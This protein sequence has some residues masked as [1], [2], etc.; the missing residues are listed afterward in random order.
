[1]SENP[2]LAQQ[3]EMP[4]VDAMV[5]A[6]RG[7]LQL[8]V[9]VG[10]QVTDQNIRDAIKDKFIE[11]VKDITGLDSNGK[12]G[13]LMNYMSSGATQHPN[14]KMPHHAA[15]MRAKVNAPDGYLKKI[16]DKCKQLSNSPDDPAISSYQI[17]EASGMDYYCIGADGRRYCYHTFTLLAATGEPVLVTDSPILTPLVISCIGTADP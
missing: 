7:R 4:P 10:S 15:D 6:G 12:V 14:P 2:T 8:D 5:V 3:E 13:A 11:K 1:M 9:A 16:G 17:A